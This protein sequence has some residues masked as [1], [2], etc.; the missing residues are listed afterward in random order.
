MAIVIEST[1]TQAYTAPTGNDITITKPT[2][3]A[4]DDLMVACVSHFAEVSNINLNFT[5]PS[6]WTLSQESGISIG[7]DGGSYAVFYK[8]ADASDVAASDFTFSVLSAQEYMGGCIMR[9]SGIRT[10]VAQLGG[11]DE[12]GLSDTDN[13]SYTVSLAPAQNTVLYVATFLSGAV[14]YNTT[15]VTITGTNPTWTQQFDT[16]VTVSDSA[17]FEVFTAIDTSPESS[18]TTLTPT[19]TGSSSNTDSYASLSFFLG[20]NDASTTPT[21]T[22]TTQD[23]FAPAGSAG[24]HAPTTLTETSN[25]ALAPEGFGNSP[26][27]WTNTTKPSTTWTNTDKD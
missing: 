16:T 15:D 10:D 20:Q 6:G 9:V 19:E 17:R 5:T 27:Q 8:L 1:S 18:I 13:P 4:V 24:A 3:L 22:A 21:F 12:E 14:P 11:S 23:A 25:T 7:G 2:G 26:T